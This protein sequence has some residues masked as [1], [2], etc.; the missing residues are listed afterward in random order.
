M[1]PLVFSDFCNILFSLV[2]IFMGLGLLY[3]ENNNKQKR[4]EKLK[5]FDNNNFLLIKSTISEINEECNDSEGPN[6][7]GE[8]WDSYVVFEYYYK[9]DMKV[10][11]N[12]IHNMAKWKVLE[13]RKIYLMFF[14]AGDEIDTIPTIV[15][16]GQ[17]YEV[18]K[19]IS[20]V[21]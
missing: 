15:I 4:L 6:A 2:Y 10:I 8:G 20:F 16:L 18:E 17:K 7:P 13:N 21:D 11:K 9:G 19:S 3:R 12:K 14:T 1:F 5:K